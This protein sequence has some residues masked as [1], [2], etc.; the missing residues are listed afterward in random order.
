MNRTFKV[1]GIHRPKEWQ[2]SWCRGKPNTQAKKRVYTSK[3]DFDKYSPDLIS[4]WEN[5]YQVE[6]YELVNDKW[7]KFDGK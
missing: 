2:E 5:Y 4:R 1:V 6:V 3:K 7:E